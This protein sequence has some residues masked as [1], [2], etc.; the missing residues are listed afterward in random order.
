MAL[1]LQAEQIE[2]FRVDR[3]R[4]PNSLDELDGRLPGVRFVR[5]GSRAYQ[6]IAYEADGT[7]IVYDSA[8]PAAE[9]EALDS[10]WV[11]EE[12]A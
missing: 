2:A 12:G 4:L 10:G 11:S 9:F 1:L 6:L 8:H 5:S 3:L 7:A